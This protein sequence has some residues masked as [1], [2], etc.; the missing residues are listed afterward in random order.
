MGQGG[1]SFINSCKAHIDRI[2]ERQ[3]C[4]EVTTVPATQPGERF[5][6]QT[7]AGRPFAVVQAAQSC[8]LGELVQNSTQIIS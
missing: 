7:G 5:L 4:S 8:R 6:R 1:Q 3:Q 2:G